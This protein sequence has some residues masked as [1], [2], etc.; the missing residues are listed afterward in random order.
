[1]N[2]SHAAAVLLLVGG[3]ALSV[4]GW[5]WFK[6]KLSRVDLAPPPPAPYALPEPGLVAPRD[7]RTDWAGPDPDAED[8]LRAA[9]AGSWQEAADLLTRTGQDWEL[10]AMRAKALG[11]HAAQDD[12]WLLAW[13]AHKPRD[14]DAALVHAHALVRLAWLIR[15]DAR[16][17]RTTREQFEGFHRV[18]REARE[19]CAEAATLADPTDPSPYI[20]E[21]PVARGL[22][23]E[24]E[25]FRSLWAEVVSRAPHHYDAHFAALQYWCA[26]WRGSQ[27]LAEEFATSAAASATAGSLLRVLPVVSW[28]EHQ[29]GRG[30]FRE[31]E[32]EARVQALVDDTAAASA[33]H[34]HL[35]AARHVLAYF[36]P[37]QG[38]TAEALEHFRA[39][40]GWAGSFPW[41]YL[42]GNRYIEVR[43]EAFRSVP[44]QV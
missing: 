16:G 3:A 17:D 42:G 10:R 12:G 11:A 8:A 21:L 13:R 1:M 15:G 22:M 28:Y 26:K 33:D 27:E 18:L 5:C 41:S 19:A 7:L 36:L 31:P 23:Y 4:V 44:T 14:A 38:R 9:D 25:D 30:L 20:A 35:V 39:V 40:D 6:W 37:L 24:H 2:N 34:P 29:G 32:I 43:D